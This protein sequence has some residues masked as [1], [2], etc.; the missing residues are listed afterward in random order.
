MNEKHEKKITYTFDDAAKS[1]FIQAHDD[2][3]TR[4]TSIED[5]EDRRGILSKGKGQ[6]VRLALVIHSLEQA[7]FGTI[8]RDFTW[9]NEID[10]ITVHKA[11]VIMDFLK[12]KNLH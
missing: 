10:D 3:C 12:I 8:E 1:V 4:K 7:V 11:K 9:K 6:V 2:L 5:D